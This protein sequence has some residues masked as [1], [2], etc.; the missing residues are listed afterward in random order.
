MQIQCGTR[1]L[2]LTSPVVMGIINVTPDSFY[3]GGQLHSRG[4]LALD[5]V[6]AK[7]EK[8]IADGAL[9]LD[10]GGESTR[11][12]A[13]AVSLQEEYDRV[14]PVVEAIAARLD[15]VIS[16]DTSTAD[17]MLAAAASG[18]G[19]INDVRALQRDGAV[20][21]VTKSKLPVCLMHMQGQPT[22]MQVQPQYQDT[23]T[24]VWQFLE[25][26]RAA[27]LDAGI[28][29]DQ[30]LV[31][32]GVG[33]GKRVE[34]NLSLIRDL[35]RFTELGPVLLGVSRKSM[36]QKLLGRPLE[37][38]LPGS[39]AVAAVAVQKGASILRVHDVAATS[40]V[41]KMTQ[42]LN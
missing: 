1:C 5:S 42:W 3:D 40:D 26:R 35:G 11:P 31:D 24:E 29:P 27:C 4:R 39:L 41:V 34:D 21:A 30:V 25:R 32:P 28:A 33:F 12:G 13:A 14:L 6:L 37:Q 38:R 2:D 8:M 22:D 16:V 19:M 17:I 7:A 36:F 20:Q 10:V 15:V 23:V 9:I 18:A